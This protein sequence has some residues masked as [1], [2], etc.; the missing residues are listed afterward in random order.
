M[1]GAVGWYLSDLKF[2]LASYL[3]CAKIH[4]LSTLGFEAVEKLVKRLQV[5]SS[6]RGSQLSLSAIGL[7]I[8]F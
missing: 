1:L 6:G 8:N 3:D 7:K 4:R 5:I 2:S